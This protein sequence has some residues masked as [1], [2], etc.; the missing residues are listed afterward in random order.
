MK[1]KN[2]LFSLIFCFLIIWTAL[3]RAE[4][5]RLEIFSGDTEVFRT[6]Y[7]VGTI[8]LGD[9]QV[10][11]YARNESNP[12]E[13]V[14]MGSAPGSTTITLWDTKGKTRDVLRITVIDKGIYSLAEEL[15][16]MLSNLEEV[17]V[18]IVDSKVVLS[19]EVFKKSSLDIVRRVVRAKPAKNIINNVKISMLAL[20]IWAE[21]LGKLIEA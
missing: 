21:E 20:K 19:G 12:K 18:K 14:I 7:E 2:F 13:I 11:S 6:Q 4:E 3:S 15:R 8:A 5:K 10:A 9:P 17:K 1:R 16:K